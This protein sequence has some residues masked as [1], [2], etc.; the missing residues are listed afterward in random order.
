MAANPGRGRARIL[1]RIA[2]IDDPTLRASYLALPDAART[3]ALAAAWLSGEEP[4]P[5]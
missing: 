4:R 1:A 5:A 3:L 2:R